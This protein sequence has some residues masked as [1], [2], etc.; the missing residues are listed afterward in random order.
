MILKCP[1]CTGAITYDPASADLMCPFCGSIFLTKDFPIPEE[2]SPS[3]ADSLA[4]QETSLPQKEVAATRGG[5]SLKWEPEEED[6]YDSNFYYDSNSSGHTVEDTM[7]CKVYHCT[8]CAAELIINDVE[9][10]TFCAYCGQ[11]TVVFDRIAK[12]RKPKYIIP[13]SVTK[14]QALSIIRKRLNQGTYIPKEIKNFQVDTLRGIYVPFWLFDVYYHDMQYLKGRV[15]SGKN[16][17]TYNYLR[18][19]DHTFRQITVDASK[20]FD[21]ASSIRLE[22]YDMSALKP[23]DITYLSGFY[24]DCSDERMDVM[25]F[26]ASERA[27]ALFNQEIVESVPAHNVTIKSSAPTHDIVDKCYAMLPVWFLVFK[28][29]ETPYT[30][31]VNGQTGKMI[32]AVPVAE[33]KAGAHIALLGT[34]LSLISIGIFQFLFSIGLAGGEMDSDIFEIFLYI[35]AYVGFTFFSAWKTRSS[36][37]RSKQ[38]TAATGIRK[39]VSDRQGGRT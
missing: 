35:L 19:A 37:Q 34:A 15:G 22:P 13:F 9:S 8:S 26:T 5:L 28:Y 33:K 6:S 32:G 30:I 20:S 11:P 17:H 29:K 16:S 3:K 36:Y 10:S 27:R 24:A 23:F 2:A 18:E 12:Q 38:L 7:E 4:S 25:N 1:N 31:M 14:T 39:Y 21:D